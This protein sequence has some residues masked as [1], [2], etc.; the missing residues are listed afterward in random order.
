[1]KTKETTSAPIVVDGKMSK[2]RRRDEEEEEGREWPPVYE[3]QGAGLASTRIML[4]SFSAGLHHNSGSSSRLNQ[5]T[6]P[7]P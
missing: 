4:S 3:K 6:S 2:G 1:V 7:V 5:L